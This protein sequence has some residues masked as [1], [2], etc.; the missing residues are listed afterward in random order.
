MLFNFAFHLFLIG[1]TQ[2]PQIAKNQILSLFWKKCSFLQFVD[3]GSLQSKNLLKAKLKSIKI[4]ISQQYHLEFFLLKLAEKCQCQKSHKLDASTLSYNTLVLHLIK[5]S[6]N[7]WHLMITQLLW[8]M[9][10]IILL[11]ESMLLPA[12]FLGNIGQAY[13]YLDPKICNKCTK[14]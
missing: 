1:G 5:S 2:N 3:F 8:G 10:E 7:L 14:V 13:L 4:V 12:S 6:T 11:F 9:M